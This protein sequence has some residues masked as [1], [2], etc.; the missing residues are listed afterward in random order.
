M[1]KVKNKNKKKMMG[2]AAAL[3][4]VT[5]LAGTFAWVAYEDARINRIKTAA[6]GDTVL[7]EVWEDPGELAPGMEAK[8]EVTAVNTGTAPTFVRVSFEE[9][10][11]HLT[12]FGKQTARA[13]GWNIPTPT[14]TDDIPVPENVSKVYD[15]ATGT[16][17]NGYVDV[18]SQVT[19]LTG[20]AKVWA[21]GDVKLN[22]SSGNLQ[23]SFDAVVAFPYDTTAG[24]YQK[25]NTSL[26]LSGGYTPVIGHTAADFTFDATAAEY[27]V[28]ANG[29]TKV[30]Y[31]WTAKNTLLGTAGNTQKD[32]GGTVAY[33]YTAP[34]TT[35]TANT[36][37]PVP[38]NAIPLPGA[39]TN[40][41]V[42]ADQTA[43]ATGLP[44]GVDSLFS[45]NYGQI[46]DLTTLAADSWVFNSDDGF[47]Y[48]TNTLK[49]GVT[50]SK[51]LESL[52]YQQVPG[53][54]TGNDLQQVKDAYT[55]LEYDLGVTMEAVQVEA[56]ALY[57]TGSQWN[58]AITGDSK[59]I[60]NKLLTSASLPAIP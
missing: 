40:V 3:G 52:N 44:A 24:K 4:L 30:G 20:G 2:L 14:A 45:I 23:A 36:A 43:L 11:T 15:H 51:L 17:V 57:G 46:T 1:K 5:L 59:T 12:E 34:G 47:F 60:L 21:K 50:T 42:L 31:D 10:L 38:T 26:T 48:Y 56:G 25:V 55:D 58:M 27:M 29:T 39:I 28:Y 9:V 32:G 16:P 19:G 13:T 33:D 37:T 7:H 49:G 18:T 41:N 6:A 35:F 53:S 54:I 8:K 22:S